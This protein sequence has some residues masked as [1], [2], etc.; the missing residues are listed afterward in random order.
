MSKDDRPRVNEACGLSLTLD[1]RGSQW[2]HGAFLLI[3]SEVDDTGFVVPRHRKTKPMTG[4]PVLVAANVNAMKTPERW[5]TLPR[6]ALF[7]SILAQ[8]P[9]NDVK[10]FLHHAVM[11][12]DKK[13]SGS[14]E[15]FKK[16][17]LPCAPGRRNMHH[18]GAICTTV[19]KGD[20]V[21]WKIQGT[22]TDTFQT[23]KE[24]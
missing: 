10:T 5:R 12:H 16:H 23:Y 22:H 24:W 4:D 8:M 2:I 18:S 19:H 9:S 6:R 13:S 20:Y 15:F 21:F 14:P 1:C 3:L 11:S 17:S 7:V